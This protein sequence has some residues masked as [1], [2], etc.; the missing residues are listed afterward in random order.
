MVKTGFL[1]ST[2][3]TALAFS[4]P[5]GAAI[6]IFV[7][8]GAIQPPENVLANTNM[9][10]Q[11]VF[12]TTNQT[13][14]SVSFTSLNAELLSSSSSN[15]QARFNTGDGTLD[16]LRFFLTNGGAFTSAEFNLFNAQGATS[17]VAIS[18]NGGA[19]QT[20]SIGNGQNFFSVLATGNDVITSISFDTNGV[21]VTDLRQVRL[22][23]ATLAVPE[24]AAWA[25]M[26]GGFGL[27]GAAMRRRSRPIEATA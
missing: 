9:T 23:G 10:A 16:T 3:G 12:G 14:T 19:A 27:M 25:M 4:A 7:G 8:P 24:P 18:V 17:S 15:G 26:L 1:V 11:T 13:N 21:G 22:G 2:V 20:F 6:Q 5:A